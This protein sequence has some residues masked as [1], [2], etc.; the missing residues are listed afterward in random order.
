VQKIKRKDGLKCR[1]KD[2]KSISSANLAAKTQHNHRAQR[3][4][5]MDGQTY[6]GSHAGKVN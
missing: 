6:D 1:F 4:R 5:Q 3:H 2:E